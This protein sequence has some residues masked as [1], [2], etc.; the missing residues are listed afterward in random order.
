M[1]QTRNFAPGE[2]LNLLH[3]AANYPLD[4]NTDDEAYVWFD[5]LILNVERE[6]GL[7]EEY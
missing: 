6:D 2:P 7:I 3:R 1:I 4:A 5:K